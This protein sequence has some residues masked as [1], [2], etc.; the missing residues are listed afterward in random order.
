M[1]KGRE[2]KVTE[3]LSERKPEVLQCECNKIL[4]L[5]HS[6]AAGMIKKTAPY[7]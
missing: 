4:L 2:I 1:F 3:A 6:R 7:P 5:L